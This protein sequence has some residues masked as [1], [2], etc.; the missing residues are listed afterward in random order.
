MWRSIVQH[1]KITL[2]DMTSPQQQKNYQKI[3]NFSNKHFLIRRVRRHL[4]TQFSVANGNKHISQ[5]CRTICRSFMQ[6]C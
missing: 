1:E 3:E 4:I 2:D 6:L 5:M